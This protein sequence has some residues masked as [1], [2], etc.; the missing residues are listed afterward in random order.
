MK[1]K[2]T[3]NRYVLAV[4]NLQTSADYYKNKLGFQT[5]WKGCGWHLLV[6]DAIKIMIGECPEDK[7]AS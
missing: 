6:R 2:I 3:G 1:P 4:N 7:P 5:L